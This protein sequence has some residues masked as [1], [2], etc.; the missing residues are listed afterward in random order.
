[1]IRSY[2]YSMQGLT[3]DLDLKRDKVMEA[4]AFMDKAIAN[5]NKV[6]EP[7]LHFFRGLL[8]F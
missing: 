7:S 6:K 2:S 3:I 5:C 4:K 8:N 1:M